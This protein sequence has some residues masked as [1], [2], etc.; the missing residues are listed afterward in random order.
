MSLRVGRRHTPPDS[1][2]TNTYTACTST[3]LYLSTTHILLRGAVSLI[4]RAEALSYSRLVGQA[5]N[6]GLSYSEQTAK[7]NKGK[8]RS[9]LL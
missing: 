3:N 2:H 4:K 9:R 8:R 6:A 7:N 5:H 1:I